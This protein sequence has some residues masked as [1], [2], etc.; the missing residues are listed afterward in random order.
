M[1]EKQGELQVKLEREEQNLEVK[2]QNQLKTLLRRIERDREEQV[3]HR[4]VD[5]QRLIQR[6]RNLINDILEK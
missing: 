2:H 3:K 4:K 5:S 6:N 1:D